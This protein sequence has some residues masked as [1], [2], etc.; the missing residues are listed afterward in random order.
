MRKLEVGLKKMVGLF[1][2]FVLVVMLVIVSYVQS[3]IIIIQDIL[4]G[5]GLV[6]VFNIIIEVMFFI[7]SSLG[8]FFIF[9]IFLIV[10]VISV[11]VEFVDDYGN[12]FDIDNDGIVDIWNCIEDLNVLG[13]WK[14]NIIFGVNVE[15][16]VYFLKIKVIVKNSIINEIID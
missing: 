16:G 9:V 3:V 6:L 1:L 14:V 5:E 8:D 7:V 12:V 2:F 4:E 10:D 11:I 15:F 13:F